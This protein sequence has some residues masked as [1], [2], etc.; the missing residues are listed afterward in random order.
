MDLPTG[1]ISGKVLDGK[2]IAVEVN[3]NS[4]PSLIKINEFE[5]PEL[6]V[7]HT[8]SE[9]KHIQMDNSEKQEVH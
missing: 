4:V 6:W 1:V 7:G 5:I 2:K 9:M 8:Q 3:E